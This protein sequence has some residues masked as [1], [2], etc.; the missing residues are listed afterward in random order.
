MQIVAYKQPSYIKDVNYKSFIDDLYKI[1][2]SQDPE[3]DKH[4]KK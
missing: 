1:E 3:E 4:I 2:I